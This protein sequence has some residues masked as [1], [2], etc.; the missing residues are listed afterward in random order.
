MKLREFLNP[1]Y[2]PHFSQLVEVTRRMMK[3]A[4]VKE[5]R[6]KT[7]YGDHVQ[8]PYEVLIGTSAVNCESRPL[9]LL[10]ATTVQYTIDI[11]MN[12][13]WQA[14]CRYDKFVGL[15]YETMVAKY[16]HEQLPCLNRLWES[17][18]NMCGTKLN[19][20]H[21]PTCK[22]ANV[23]LHPRVLVFADRPARFSF[24]IGFSSRSINS[25]SWW[26]VEFL[27]RDNSGLLRN[28]QKNNR[29]PWCDFLSRCI[30]VVKSM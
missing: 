30:G 28:F 29:E 20:K 10:P 1:A 12:R 23:L 9:E 25:G 21:H 11:L 24:D 19:G 16:S 3:R 22:S 5:F 6:Y 17:L 26:G 4:T 14:I 7:G 13:H 8:G 15:D 18:S 2:P 27:L